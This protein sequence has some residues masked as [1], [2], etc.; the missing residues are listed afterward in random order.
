[1]SVAATQYSTS[2]LTSSSS[3][4]STSSRVAQKTLGQSDFL[5]LITVQLANQ[6]PMDPMDDTSF[7][8]QM[9]QFSALENSTQL[10]KEFAKLRTTTDLTSASNLIGKEVTVF[11]DDGTSVT[12]TV[13]GVDTTLETPR[14]VIDDKLYYFANVT[15]VTTPT[16]TTTTTTT[17]DGTS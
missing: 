4:T 2:S 15:K 16:T 1:M 6:D 14:L 12:G 11:A 9:A 5:Q 7:I 3:T 17:S 8:A 13:S 10:S